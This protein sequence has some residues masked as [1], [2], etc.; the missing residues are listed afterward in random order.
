MMT[1]CHF[2]SKQGQKILKIC[3][4]TNFGSGNSNMTFVTEIDNVFINY[5]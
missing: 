4:P 2:G 1:Y 3:T 5:P